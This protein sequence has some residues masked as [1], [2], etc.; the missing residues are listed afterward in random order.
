VGI[1][2]I[3]NIGQEEMISVDAKNLT[4]NPALSF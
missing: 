3:E 4:L 1:L 2:S